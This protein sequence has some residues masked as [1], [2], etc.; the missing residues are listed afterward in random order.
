MFNSKGGSGPSYIPGDNYMTCD[1]CGHK[2][3]ASKMRRQPHGLWKGLWVCPN[4]YD[5]Y[6]PQ[7]ED[8]R[9]PSEKI[10]PDKVNPEPESEY[11]GVEGAPRVGFIFTFSLGGDQSDVA[12]N[13][14]TPTQ[15]FGDGS[16]KITADDL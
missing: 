10:V 1:I 14:Q 7:F 8:I 13:Y 6:N 11:V 15:V 12:P 16:N 3:R 9:L 2:F 5:D 4:D